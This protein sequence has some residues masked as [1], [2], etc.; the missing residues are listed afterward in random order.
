[1]IIGGGPAGHSAATYGAR[2]GAEVVLIERD[3]I[4]G[5]AH[6]W[7][8]IPSKAMIATGGALAF[9]ARS[10]GM[11]LE[12]VNPHIDIENL[13]A[14]LAGIENKLTSSTRRVLESQNINI[15]CG[16]GSIVGPHTV[17][18]ETSDGELEFEADYI[19]LCTGSRPRIPEWAPID[20]DRVLTTRDAYPPKEMPAHLVVIGSGVTGVEF[21]HM[22][23]SFGS[24]VTL[25]VSRQQV[26]P[27]KDPEVAAALET[28]FLRRNV[29]LMKG[30]R[31]TAIERTEDGVRVFSEDGRVA[32]GSHVLLAIGSIPNSESLGL[33]NVGIETDHGYIDVDHHCRS[34]MP[35][36]YAAGDLS[37]R[38]PLSSVASMQ[39]RKIA[40]HAM[41]MHDLPHRHLD[42]DKAASAIFTEPEI[43]DV[44]LA[45]VDAFAEGRK[46]RV[47]KVPFSVSAKALINDDPRGFVKIISD[48][49]TGV[50]LGGSI[51]G[52]HAA[53]LISVLAIAVTAHLTVNDIVESLLVHPTLAEVLAEAAE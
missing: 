2:L 39:G 13:R 10:E 48:P 38:L 21:V 32:E 24:E 26:L 44:G 53:E 1:M 18:A 45:E 14:R 9:L 34:S 16:S 51:V 12:E 5:A 7:D 15:V 46:I 22:F 25:L 43:A 4:G 27:Q 30:A 40:E 52:R 37:G 47:T 11:G 20:G 8:C 23:R 42:Y 31:A 33:Q 35:H 28:D 29:N 19:V 36:I 49:A 17:K 41:G 3:V 6:I 50:I